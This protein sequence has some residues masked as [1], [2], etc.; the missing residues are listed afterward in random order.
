MLRVIRP[1]FTLVLCPPFS[2]RILCLFVSTVFLFPFFI[3]LLCYHCLMNIAPLFNVSLG[4][5]RVSFPCVSVM[6]HVSLP[7]VPIVRAF[8]MCHMSL[9][10]NFL[11]PSHV[12]SCVLCP[13][14]VPHFMCH[15]S[16]PCVLCQHRDGKLFYLPG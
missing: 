3:F 7:C 14:H 8:G 11:C 2:I 10:C 5:G 1:L 12:M 15:V 13:S 4:V 16:F 6:C 9:P